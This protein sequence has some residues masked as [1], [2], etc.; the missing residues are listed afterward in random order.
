MINSTFFV[1]RG[2][3]NAAWSDNLTK[4]VAVIVD[5][6]LY[7]SIQSDVERYTTSYIQARQ[8]DT[9]AIVLPVNIKNISAPD[10]TKILE[11]IY[12]D[13]IQDVP[14][15]LAG[16][17]LLGNIPLPVIQENGYVYP[18]IFPYVDF[19]NQKFIYD[20]NKNFFVPNNNPNGQAEIRHGIINFTGAAQYSKYFQKLKNYTTDPETFVDPQIW[21]DDFIGNKK[22]YIAENTNFY[23]NKQIFAEDIWYHR[24]NNLLFN[25]LKWEYNTNATTLGD[26]LQNNLADTEQQSLKD[27]ATMIKDKQDIAGPSIQAM[28]GNKTPTLVLNKSISELTKTYDGLL[29]TKLLTKIQDNIKAAARRYAKDL[30]GNWMTNVSSHYEKIVQRDNRTI[31][32]QPLLIQMNNG[33]E[34]GLNQKIA[35]EKYAM[36]IPISIAFENVTYESLIHTIYTH[37]Q[38]FYFGQNANTVT[39]LND[40]SIYRGTFQNL[41]SLTGT[42]VTTPEQSV[43]WSYHI[44]SQQIEA[45]R[46][47]N[48]LN[49]EWELASRQ[50][51][52]QYLLFKKDCSGFFIP[53]DNCIWSASWDTGYGENNDFTDIFNETVTWSTGAKESPMDF[54]IRQRWGASPINLNTW[55]LQSTNTYQLSVYDFRQAIK[56]VFDI[57]G[58]QKTTTAATNLN[59]YIGTQN[60]GSLIKTEDQ[61]GPVNYPRAINTIS[62]SHDT[63]TVINGIPFVIK[64]T[65]PASFSN[66]F[67]IFHTNPNQSSTGWLNTPWSIITLKWL[68]DPNGWWFSDYQVYTYKLIDTTKKNIAP[69][70]AEI[71]GMNITTADRPIDSIRNVTFQ[72]IGGDTVQL[73][74]PNLYEVS[75]YKT[76]GNM[77]VLKT[78]TEI[79]NALK[80]YLQ[81]KVTDYNNALTT[82][83]NK[84]TQFYQTHQAAFD[85][86]GLNDPVATPNRTYNLLPQDYLIQQLVNNL[87]TLAHDYWSVY[88][89]G[90]QPANTIDQKLMVIAKLLSYQ[91]SS[92]PERKIET[93]VTKEISSLQDNFNINKKI[94]DTANIY[95]QSKHNEWAFVSPTYNK[96]WYEV[97]FINSDGFDLIDNEKPSW[98][99]TQLQSIKTQKVEQANTANKIL[100]EA[101]KDPTA[102]EVD[103]ECGVD[104]NGTSLLFDIKTGKSPWMAAMSCWAENIFKVKISI[105]FKSAL[106]PT[107]AGFLQDV[108]ESFTSVSSQRTNY[109]AAM[110]QKD[111]ADNATAL[112]NSSPAMQ[113]RLKEY[114]DTTD[115]QTSASSRFVDSKEPHT[116]TISSFRTLEKTQVR[117]SATGDVC[118]GLQSDTKTVSSNLCTSPITF[119]L[120]KDASIYTLVD[121]TNKHKAWSMVITTDFCVWWSMTNCIAKSKTI[122]T[123]PAAVSTIR[124]QTPTEIMMMWAS[125]PIAFTAQDGYGN[126]IGQTIENYTITPQTGNINGLASMDFNNFSKGTFLYQAPEKVTENM[127][128]VVKIQGTN[129]EGK[130]ITG[131]KRII[132]AKGIL[133]VNYAG[134]VVF[135]TNIAQARTIGYHLPATASD[136]VKKDSNN[137]AQVQTAAIPKLT[138][139]LQDKN[140]NKLDTVANVSSRYWLLMPGKLW[141]NTLNISGHTYNQTTFQAQGN[142]IITGGN[143]DIRLY[144][145][146]KAGAEEIII[147]IPWLDPI[148][149]AINVYPGTASKVIIQLDDTSLSLSNSATSSGIITVLDNRNNIVKE[150]T[151]LKIWALGPGLINNQ[152]SADI[153]R[154]GTPIPFTLKGKQPGGAGH[155]FAY[156]RDTPLTDQEPAE[157]TF[158]V[159]NNVLPETGLNV[160]YLNLFW[161]DRWN[162]RGYFSDNDQKVN[163]LTETSDKLLTTTTSLIDPTKIKQIKVIIAPDGQLQNLGEEIHSMQIM[164]GQV[165]VEVPTVGTINYGLSKLFSII[166]LTSGQVDSRSKD[167]NAIIYSAEQTDSNITGNTITD[168]RLLINGKAV[169]DFTAGTMDTSITITANGETSNG[170]TLYDVLQNGTKLGSLAIYKKT[171]TLTDADIK[172]TDSI[173]YAK[174]NIFTQASTNAPMGIGIFDTQSSYSKNGYQSIEDSTDPMAGIWFT[175]KFK[176]ISYFAA[177][178][179]VG[180]STLP[181]GSAFLINFGDPMVQR[182]SDSIQI[183]KTQ[184]D[185]S[186][187]QEI[188]SSPD[189]TIFKTIPTDFNR[190]GI[191][192]LLVA[193]TDGS[194][195]LLKNYGGKQPFQN[196]GN[197]MI[198]WDTIKEIHVGDVNGDK[199]PDMLIWT[200]ADKLLVYQNRAGIMDVDGTPV[201]LN[202]NVASNEVTSTP[203]DISWV[204]QI[205]VDDMD[206]DDNLDIITNDIA[207]D[208]KIFYGGK[209]SHGNG[210]Y[211]STL[212]GICDDGRFSRQQN[213]QQT[214]RSFGLKINPDRYITDESLAHRKGMIVPDESTTDDESPESDTNIDLPAPLKQ[215]GSD[216]NSGDAAAAATDFVDKTAE[217]TV[218][219]AKNLSFVDNPFDKIPSYEN[220]TKDQV[221]YLP[222]S[223][224]SG[225]KISIYKQYEDLNGGI[226]SAGDQVKITIHILSLEDNK[227]ITYLEKLSGPREIKKDTNDKILS[228]LF[229]G[230]QT[231][232]TQTSRDVWPDYQFM[233]DNI[234][235]Q[236][237]QSVEISY[238]VNYQKPALTKITV[239]DKDLSSL[240]KPID[241]YPDIIVQTSDPCIKSQRISRNTRNHSK[242]YKEYQ[243]LVKDL[244]T[245][246]SDYTSGARSAQENQLDASFTQVTNTT[247]QTIASLPGVSQ[248]LETWD[249]KDLFSEWWLTQ[250]LNMNFIDQATAGVS[251]KLDEGLKWLCEGFKLSKQWCQWIPVPF[252][253]AFLAP[254]QY[255]VFGCIPKFPPIGTIFQAIN[256]TIGKWFP[257]LSFP[258]NSTI[259]IWPPSP[260]G[261]WGIF[262]WSTS[263]FRLYIAPTMTLGLGIAICV[264]PYS[265]GVKLPKPI[266][267]IGGNCI[268]FAIPWAMLPCNSDGS[269]NDTATTKWADEVDPD[270]VNNNGSCQNPPAI[271]NRIVF[272]SS[273]NTIAT[274]PKWTSSPLQAVDTKGSI[275]NPLVPQGNFGGLMQMN[276]EP[277]ITTTTE[278][279]NN[280][281]IGNTDIT[282]TPGDKVNLKILGGKAKW[283]IKCIVWD[284]MTRQLKFIINNL[285]KMTIQVNLPDMSQMAQWFDTIGNLW[286]TIK[287]LNAQ[288]DAAWYTTSLNRVTT[289]NVLTGLKAQFSRQQWATISNKIGQNPFEAIAMMFKEVPLINLSTKD[290]NVKIPSLTTEEITKYGSYLQAW[291]AKNAQIVEDRSKILNK[292]LALCGTTSKAEAQKMKDT[293]TEQKKTITDKAVQAILQSEIDE[294][295][296]IIKLP[297]DNSRE[298]L[299]SDRANLSINIANTTK[300]IATLPGWKVA[301]TVLTAQKIKE[302]SSFKNQVLLDI[303]TER[304]TTIGKCSGIAWSINGFLSFKTNTDKLMSSIQDN[305]KVL[306]Q[307]K[308][309]PGQLYER[310]HVTDRYIWEIGSI[311][312]EFVGGLTTWLD[313]NANRFS[314]YVDA[315]TLIIGAIKTW[316]AI[317]DFSLNRSEK[318]SKCSNDNYGSFSC[319]LSFLCPQLPIFKIPSF[320]IPDITL[321][322]SH[323][324]VGL[325]IVLPKF[326]FVPIKIPLPELPSLPEP[327]T[328][329]IDLNLL[330]NL[331]LS[332]FKDMQVPSIPVLPWPPQLPELPSFIPNIDLK[333]P[334]LPPAPKIPKILPEISAILDVADFI[335][336]VF[337][338]VKWGIG[339]VGEKWVKAKIEQL[340]QRKWN[341][342]VFDFFD[343]TSKYKSPPLEWFD[344]QIDAYVRLKYNFE[345]VYTLLDG[346]A[347]TANQVV[348]STIEAP[349]QEAANKI[350]ETNNSWT[351][352]LQQLPDGQLN[353]NGLLPMDATGLEY[354]DA[355]KQLQQWL[356]D[357]SQQAGQDKKVLSQIDTIKWTINSESNVKPASKQLQQ[358]RAIADSIVQDKQQEVETLA[359]QVKDYDHFI[360][361]VQRNQIQLVSQKDDINT[362]ISSPLITMNETT[363]QLIASQEAP[364]TTY[365][366]LNKT[367]VQWYQKTLETS[368]ATD[369]NMTPDTYN[370]S[371]KY[372]NELAQKIDKTQTISNEQEPAKTEKIL[373]AAGGCNGG[374]CQT[375]TMQENGYTQDLTSYAQGIL[376]QTGDNATGLT[377]VNVV[378]N[379]KIA[380]EIGKNYLQIDMNNDK[381]KDLLMRDTNTIYIKYAKQDDNYRTAGGSNMT[382]TYTRYFNYQNGNKRRLD[383]M[384]DAAANT[385]NGYATFG[386]IKVKIYDTYREVKNFKTEGQSFDTLQMT[387][388]NSMSMGENISWYIIKINYDVENFFQ[389][390]KT[391]NFFGT[392]TTPT[393]YILVLPTDTNY[394]TG[395]LSIERIY[396]KAIKALLTGEVWAVKYFDPGD[397]RISISMT[398]VPSKWMYAQIAPLRQDPSQL[399]NA[400]NRTLALFTQWWPWSNQIVAGKQVLADVQGPDGTITLQRVLTNEAISTG[401]THEWR[402]NTNYTLKAYRE[403]MVA[404]TH[405]TIEHNGHTIYSKTWTNITGSV[406]IPNLFFTGAMEDTYTFKATDANNNISKEVVK[407][408]IQI[409][410]INITDVRKIDDQNAEIIAEIEN[411]LDEG[412][413]TFQRARNGLIKPITGTTA[414]SL[415]GYSL[416]PKQKI[417]TGGIMS[418]GNTLWLYT[419]SG[420]EIGTINPDNG[421][422]IINDTRKNKVSLQ[423]DFLLHIPTIKVIQTSNQQELF[424]ISL[425]T[426]KMESIVMKQ[427]KP[428]YQIAGLSQSQFADFQDGS[429]IQ[430]A[431]KEC[432]LYVNS[433]G[434]IYVP[435]VYSSMLWGSYSFDSKNK[436]ILYTIADEKGKAIAIIALQIKPLFQ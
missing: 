384:D 230:S 120:G 420:E 20:Q 217:Y 425:P 358:A 429:C 349:M 246:M 149:I 115:V 300:K 430:N 263:Q 181:Y 101:E 218:A 428:A 9:K 95:L 278:A 324:E 26:D 119:T 302:G 175:S 169:I 253:Q 404:V 205:F 405:M 58:A 367:L 114:Q 395:L 163:Q 42:T 283:L 341:V 310:V 133:N 239:E 8:A 12:F 156:L 106:G 237:N 397:E 73:N 31:G 398:D 172:V 197:V 323:I 335:G 213:N 174:E 326:N 195:Q 183:S 254:G 153:V 383:S 76:V 345:W 373:L 22:Y 386:N 284:W 171:A 202:T 36:K 131:E 82:Q 330:G 374:T 118:L 192:D 328:Y 137:I 308:K 78:E 303:A 321:D 233:I 271:G 165:I 29:S 23:I 432:I 258:T 223:K 201:C 155:L 235:L 15:K 359:D 28:S 85:F 209:D 167:Q 265:L 234:Q 108:G 375:D 92:W 416:S 388:K 387:R 88:V 14:S 225:E 80:V 178:K 381:A 158:F 433:L 423:L 52:R 185:G 268:V 111:D 130:V 6:D 96:T 91:N 72:G 365:I 435:N 413:V 353:I 294:M 71:S 116:L 224:L 39:N 138:L 216:Y 194:I 44:F 89:Y 389:K 228:L 187:G 75:V 269:V 363:K 408:K 226:L 385:E 314:Q 56:P 45:N 170:L 339:L 289:G 409:P 400:Q 351:E 378:N 86:L 382:T 306:E 290:I 295:N 243:D 21:Y 288:D 69:F 99:I 189:K 57:A 32:A 40:I 154:N 41:N 407:L 313:T 105:N 61:A 70:P 90:D 97:A 4:I 129:A 190:D 419:P 406:E 198:I 390:F 336:K 18:S 364:N 199:F 50:T 329:E 13:G 337:C 368:N 270:L 150:P 46:G 418:L 212:T 104:V 315:I 182:I 54:A 180:Q 276:Q 347:Q 43:W 102:T 396:K 327:P 250:N 322:L 421:E 144:P 312:S 340:T 417:I 38:N 128:T 257:I 299:W 146:L 68:N 277:T 436:T 37:Y 55:I 342:P 204:H 207:G 252:N 25:T 301:Q 242:G 166:S 410:E 227:K 93:S 81:D 211:L 273:N 334:V 344:Y 255:H 394:A 362:T 79:L 360:T 53:P 191:Q 318:C 16:I 1:D 333:L 35:T 141:S 411:D 84:K 208:V 193:Y 48:L 355:Y 210:Y 434:K 121:T 152:S 51:D 66:F 247:A 286:D 127:G 291:M 98:F 274:S 27:Y 179:T 77:L 160:M 214:V 59:N 168:K 267:D 245:A 307:Y 414:N 107:V 236:T 64:D 17:V 173:K 356:A 424:Q 350:T 281:N 196:L 3:V 348:T 371:T 112:Q 369:L 63:S 415:G 222:I 309:F 238:V 393:K 317:I 275:N 241:G 376:I 366:A 74:Y 2:K 279:Q 293:L 296:V 352:V 343:L 260:S 231:Q 161:T 110:Q 47:Y 249:I 399:T 126:A 100:Q 30:S 109:G 134:Q 117:V 157:Q 297:N 361:D 229:T 431:N 159:Q 248:I 346:I 354:A 87:D 151:N 320:K 426:Q 380:S 24:V 65:I 186:A 83:Q 332:L 206:K 136:L 176:N 132:I 147:N 142:I 422:I 221:K 256:N 220:L 379:Q 266:R 5:K 264:W 143:A 10:I 304:A 19:E 219:G 215:D 135:S 280:E 125:L 124:A 94:S 49:T 311:T 145:S 200:N 232:H 377:M 261:A 244:D 370:K 285:T 203:N 148:R 262:G 162:Q 427:G 392:E 60:Y 357:F 282:L 139:V 372:L 259:P 402:I 34:S 164:S 188:F 7:P 298:Q 240:N 403:D 177:G 391:F 287:K 325:D 140:G 292:M 103:T 251:K 401:N 305:I 319:S 113:T 62:G 33:L 331:D 338:I 316:Q 412:L 184:F 122:T 123:L 11:N 67:S 272:A